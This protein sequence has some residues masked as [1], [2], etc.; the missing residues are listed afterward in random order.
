MR[1]GEDLGCECDPRAA[2]AIPGGVEAE[3]GRPAVVESVF[4][5]LWE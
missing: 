4:P 1:L 5:F 2:A 3:G